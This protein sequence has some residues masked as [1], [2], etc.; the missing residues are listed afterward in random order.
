MYELEF[1]VILDGRRVFEGFDFVDI[2]L[3]EVLAMLKEE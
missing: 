2:Y 3:L 1:R